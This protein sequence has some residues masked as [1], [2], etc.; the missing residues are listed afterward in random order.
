MR[1]TRKASGSRGGSRE[2]SATLN[3]RAPRSSRSRSASAVSSEDPLHIDSPDQSADVEVVPVARGD[4][5]NADD[6]IVKI[7][8]IQRSA[9]MPTSTSERYRQLLST[10][11]YFRSVSGQARE[12]QKSQSRLYRAVLLE[13]VLTLCQVTEEQMA[14]YE[15]IIQNFEERRPEN[16]RTSRST[17]GSLSEV[18]DFI[19]GTDEEES[20]NERLEVNSDS[21][22]APKR[23][24]RTRS[25][26]KKKPKVKEVVEP[27]RRSS[28]AAK[29][30][31]SYGVEGTSEPDEQPEEE[32]EEEE[33]AP[34]TKKATKSNKQVIS[35]KW[36]GNS[37]SRAIDVDSDED[38]EEEVPVSALLMHRSVSFPLHV[39]HSKVNYDDRSA[40]NATTREQMSP[41]RNTWREIRR[42]RRAA[43]ESEIQMKTKR[44]RA[45]YAQK[46]VG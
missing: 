6:E 26:T 5:L 40:K 32:S 4:K 37:K 24:S 16:R 20:D 8:S 13:V 22:A 28:R 38:E 34:Q 35:L 45:T 2:V 36:T 14:S 3:V 10:Y 12:R 19:A 39:I 25:K 11:I 43:S 17:A 9:G 21:D 42:R 46:A 31:A 7:L 15:D 41:L 1:E 44:V 18:E 30:N 29:P 23:K 33:E 27:T